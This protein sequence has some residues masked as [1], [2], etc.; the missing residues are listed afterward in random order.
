M[1][2]LSVRLTC[3]VCMAGCD[4]PQFMER[5]ERIARQSDEATRRMRELA[6]ENATLR[7]QEQ[8][9]STRMNTLEQ[10]IARLDEAGAASGAA[11]KAADDELQRLRAELAAARRQPAE[12]ARNEQQEAA[13]RAELDALRTQLATL[14][15]QAKD[16]DDAR[17]R[18]ARGSAAANGANASGAAQA[19]PDKEVAELRHKLQGLQA[20]AQQLDD[21]RRQ[22]EQ[23]QRDNEEKARQLA[24]RQRDP[25]APVL[26]SL[27]R[28]VVV[29]SF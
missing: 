2:R 16:L 9:R 21:Y 12:Q 23:L 4:N 7:K 25:N 6:D 24:E 10:R 13:H 19:V 18:P 3:H 17:A 26:R 5:L 14:Q 22:V 20:Q 29:P 1:G 8:E 27:P 28:S 11:G 15:K